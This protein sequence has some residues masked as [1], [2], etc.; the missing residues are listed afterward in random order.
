MKYF[1]GIYWRG[2]KVWIREPWFTLIPLLTLIGI[3]GIVY[4]IIK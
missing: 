1:T 4:L 2:E 3:G